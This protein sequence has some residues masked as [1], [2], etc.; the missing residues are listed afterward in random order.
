MIWTNTCYMFVL[1]LVNNE[2]QSLSFLM[3][4]PVEAMCAVELSDKEF[5]LVFASLAVYVDTRGRR[6]RTEEIMWPS[7]PNFV[8]EYHCIT[9]ITL[10]VSVCKKLPLPV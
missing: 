7:V 6:S 1:A 8:S 10:Y 2:D 3:Q 5:L 4:A 9:L